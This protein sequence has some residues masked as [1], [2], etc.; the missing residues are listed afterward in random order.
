MKKHLL[1]SEIV[2]LLENRGGYQAKRQI[3]RNATNREIVR[4]LRIT[5]DRLTCQILC[6]ILGEKHAKTAVEILLLCLN[7]E[8]E[9]VRASAADALAKIKD[10]KTG[11]SLLQHLKKEPDIGAKAMIII[12]VGA[13]G[14]KPAIPFLIPLLTA[15]DRSIRGS[16]AWSLGALGAYEAR[17]PLQVALS[18]EIES[19][20][21]E[22]IQETLDIISKMA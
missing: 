7:H 2:G 22:R 4:A 16:A 6:D 21:K 19:Y 11:Q 1:A 12:A 13:V 14:Y 18:K 8:S 15:N 3:L 10:A 5:T 20:P 17:E 9:R